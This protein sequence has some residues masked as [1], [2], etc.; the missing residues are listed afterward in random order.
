MIQKVIPKALINILGSTITDMDIE[1][2]TKIRR[3]EYL[4]NKK[5]IKL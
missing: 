3:K 1:L 5:L 4:E 2:K